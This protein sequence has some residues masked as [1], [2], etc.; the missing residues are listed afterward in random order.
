MARRWR[1]RSR[2]TAP[3]GIH[4][5]QRRAAGRC[6]QSADGDPAVV[7]L[8]DLTRPPLKLVPLEN[9]LP[10]TTALGSD[11]EVSDAP[12]PVRIPPTTG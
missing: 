1:R 7:D 9:L 2:S 10:S 12:R 4:D 6:D 8:I 5:R 3:A 11:T